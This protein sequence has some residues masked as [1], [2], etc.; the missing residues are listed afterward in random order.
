MHSAKR[1]LSSCCR[2]KSLA[3]CIYKPTRQA[4]ALQHSTTTGPKVVSCNPSNT[5]GHTGSGRETN[6]GQHP[7][8]HWHI[9]AAVVDP[10]TANDLL[11]CKIVKVAY[12][13]IFYTCDTKKAVVES[14]TAEIFKATI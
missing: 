6:I 1:L 4:P 13:Y 9:G 14:K 12:I 3:E 10:S 11:D 5:F 8:G 7:K 2:A